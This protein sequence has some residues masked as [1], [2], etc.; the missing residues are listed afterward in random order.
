MMPGM[1]GLDLIREVRS[2]PDYI[3]ALIVMV[4]TVDQQRDL[5]CRPEAATGTSTKPVDMAEAARGFGI[6]AM[7]REM[8][9]KLGIGPTGET[10]ACR[11]PRPAGT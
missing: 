3:I 7:L 2:L 11:D 6:W 1:D 8:Q 5:L 10:S 9:N 4:T